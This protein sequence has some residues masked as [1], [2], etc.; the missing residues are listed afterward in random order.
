[1]KP[2]DPANTCPQCGGL[3]SARHAGQRYVIGDGHGGVGATY[4]IER[5]CT[6]CGVF[7]SQIER[8]DGSLGT[9]E[10]MR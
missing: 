5:K 9:P 2:I 7:T 8:E 6:A 4:A 1:M 3:L 10:V